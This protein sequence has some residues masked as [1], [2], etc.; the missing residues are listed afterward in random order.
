MAAAAWILAY[1]AAGIG[2]FYNR[3]QRLQKGLT[4][5]VGGGMILAGIYYAILLIS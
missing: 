3:M 5:L 4:L 1:G 2:V